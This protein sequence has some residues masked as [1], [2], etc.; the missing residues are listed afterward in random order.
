MLRLLIRIVAVC[1]F[2]A[3]VVGQD[4]SVPSSWRVE[5][6]AT[7][8]YASFT[9]YLDTT[10]KPTSSL[11]RAGRELLASAVVDTMSTRFTSGQVQGSSSDAHEYH[12]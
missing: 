2:C 4:L 9:H 12:S 1:L 10:Q 3:L 5:Y 8:S 11:P 7:I 6:R